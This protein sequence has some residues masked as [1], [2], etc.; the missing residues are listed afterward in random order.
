MRSGKKNPKKGADIFESAIEGI[1]SSHMSRH[2]FVDKEDIDSIVR[3][4][5]YRVSYEYDV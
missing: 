2:D 5:P 1:V 4:E 3:E